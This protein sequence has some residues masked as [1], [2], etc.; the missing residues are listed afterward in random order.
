MRHYIRD[1]RTPKVAYRYTC[2]GYNNT[3]G[4]ADRKWIS[5]WYKLQKH[6]LR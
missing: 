1:I 6:Y 5:M 3:S 2:R 4:L